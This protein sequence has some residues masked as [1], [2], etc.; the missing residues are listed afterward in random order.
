M[1]LSVVAQVV[2][3]FL[4]TIQLG[5]GGGTSSSG[6]GTNSGPDAGVFAEVSDNFQFKI[7]NASSGLTLGIAGEKQTSG[8]AVEQSSDAGTDDQL[9]HF[10]AM[11]NHQFN[12]EDLLSHQVLGIM[13][14]SQASGAIALQWADNGTADHIW[15][16]YLLKDGNYLVRNANSGLY[17]EDKNSD[18]TSSGVIDQ[19]VR[20]TNPTGCTCQEWV[21]TSTGTSPYPAPLAVSGSG[22]AVHDPYLLKDAG[23]RYWLYGTHNTLAG[24]TDLTTF[25]SATPDMSPDFPWWKTVNLTWN[26]GLNTDM[27]APDVMYSAGTYYQYYALPFE[28]HSGPQAIIALA[29]SGNPNGPWTDAGQILESF[30]TTSGSTT[31]FNAIDP[32]PF[33]DAAGNWWLV[34]GSWT[35]E[36]HLIQLDRATGLRLQSNT[37]LYTIAARGNPS[38]GEEGPFIYPDNGWYY[39]FA[40]INVCCSGVSST[41][42]IVVGRSQSVTGPYLDRGGIDLM[43]GGG[44][45]LLGAHGNIQGPGGQSVFIDG[46]QPTLVYHYYDGNNNGAPT[47]GINRLGFDSAGWPFVQ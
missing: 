9:W 15:Q 34:F 22:T 46:S 43:Q 27:W 16:F 47:L 10:L 37:T 33:A 19:A 3:S 8:A 38:A 1:R 21:L 6:G 23:G 32:A 31:T 13:N 36:I 5:C 14:A 35:D 39:Y 29:T 24:S 12:L 4:T 18:P 25:V 17:L 40:S 28:P 7:K 30:G 41:Y 2:L 42:R 11:G 20:I 44:T 45:I 26:N